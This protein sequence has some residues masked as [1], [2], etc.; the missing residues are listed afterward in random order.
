M[1]TA[2]FSFK[3]D[4]EVI[5]SPPSLNSGETIVLQLVNDDVE[6]DCTDVGIW[7]S[8]SVALGTY[9]DASAD[10][11]DVDYQTLLTW[12]ENTVAE[13]DTQGGLKI[14]YSN[15]V[16]EVTSYFSRTQGGDYSTRIMLEDI[17]AG[18]DIEVV[19]ELETPTGLSARKIYVSLSVG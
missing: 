7:L 1:L 9:E 10:S 6:E 16:G 3:I 17:P 13:V 15:G 4:D 2:G 12:G 8:P 14:T 5:Y 18:G 19:L 11:P